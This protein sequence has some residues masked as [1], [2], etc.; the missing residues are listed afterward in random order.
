MPETHRVKLPYSITVAHRGEVP[1]C[2]PMNGPV[3]A[4]IDHLIGQLMTPM[5]TMKVLEI[6]SQ[7]SII[8]IAKKY[9]IKYWRRDST[10]LY[11][12]PHVEQ[13]A[14]W[15]RD[16]AKDNGLAELVV[17]GSSN[18]LFEEQNREEEKKREQEATSTDSER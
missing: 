1:K 5:D 8:K 9:K 17:P 18:K 11:Y 6:K 4:Q 14:C 3:E 16:A 12:R 2:I 13:V 7:R 10:T 15:R